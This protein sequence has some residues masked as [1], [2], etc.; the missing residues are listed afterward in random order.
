MLPRPTYTAVL[1]AAG[2]AATT[3]YVLIDKSDITNYPHTRIGSINLLSLS[4]NAE[5]ASD[6]DFTIIIGVVVEND[7]TNGSIVGVLNFHLSS[8]QNPTDSTDRFSSFFWDLTLG[9][10]NQEGLNLSVVSGALTNIIS[11]IADDDNTVWQ[12]D[13][14]LASPAGAAGGATGKPG[15]G[16]LVMLVTENA[17]TGNIDFTATV[18]YS[19]D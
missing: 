11:N 5:K 12:N 15:V 14:G 7:E 17:E 6:G 19:T 16:D 2:V 10:G 4:F 18:L 13:T 9:G 8:N 1:N 3:G